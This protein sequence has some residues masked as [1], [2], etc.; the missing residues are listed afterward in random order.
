MSYLYPQ[1]WRIY[2]EILLVFLRAMG[3]FLLVP[4]FSHNAIPGQVKLLFALSLSLV[5]HPIVRQYLMPLDNSLSVLIAASLRET[6]IG[7][8]MGFVGYMV[9]EGAHLAAQFVGY[10][11]GFG[12]SGLL[13][14]Q[15][16]SSVSVMVHLQSWIVLVLFFVTDLHHHVIQIFVQSFMA[17]KNLDMLI[18]LN[19]ETLKVITGVSAQIFVLA[20]QLAAP[21]TLL[22]LLCNVLIS[23]LA[24]AMPQMNILLFSFPVTIITGLITFYLI[25]PELVDYLETVLGNMSV[26]MMQV[27]RTL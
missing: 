19:S 15:S 9:C 13:E 7:F 25:T 22:V 2:L 12:T 3:L 5:I 17:T 27:L 11:M 26:N 20:I 4:G 8:L 24:R 18:G 23:V 21:F 6:I 10:Q 16:Q 1:D 14:P